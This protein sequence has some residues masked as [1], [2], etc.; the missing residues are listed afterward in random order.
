MTLLRWFV[1]ALLVLPILLAGGAAW[2][3]P[4]LG[5]AMCPSCYGFERIAPHVFVQSSMPAG[6]RARLRNDLRA[7]QARV[8]RHL[9]PF[10]E[11]YAVLVCAT[12]GCD[13]RL[14]GRGAPATTFTTPFGSAI[15][16]AP[17]GANRTI[18]AH[19]LAHVR[20]HDLAGW[21]QQVSGVLPAWFDEGLAVIVS[22]DRR[23]LTLDGAPRACGEA[24][25]PP[26]PASPFDWAPR[27]G[28]EP[29]IYAHAV[30]AVARWMDAHGGMDGAIAALRAGTTG[31]IGALR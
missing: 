8:A 12:F 13:R 5:A 31:R 16:V 23:Y 21:R 17:R 29:D 19:E 24:D 18:L 7:A 28:R 26:L 6:Q 15:R 2:A 22:D 11:R 3:Y 9:G 1:G 4:T 14:G 20:I 27:S 25:A 10:P 30:C